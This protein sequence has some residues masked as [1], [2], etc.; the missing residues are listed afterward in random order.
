MAVNLSRNTAKCL[1]RPRTS[2]VYSSLS[3]DSTIPA[4]KQKLIPES[5]TYP[6]GFLIGTGH[7]GVKAS[8]KSRDDV[9]IVAS[10]ELCYGIGLFTS[11]HFQAAPVTVSKA[12]SLRNTGKNIRGVVVNSG[13]A[14]AVTGEEGLD[15]AKQMSQAVD[16]H[17]SNL[18]PNSRPNDENTFVMSTGVIGQK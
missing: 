13:C 15:H 10:P 17:F 11:S 8:N 14:N 18:S 2:R 16:E 9:A 6:K 1:F 3:S 12:I 4:S 7:A 5:G